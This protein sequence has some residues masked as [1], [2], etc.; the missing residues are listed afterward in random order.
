MS[1]RSVL[2]WLDRHKRL[3]A[4]LAFLALLLA[5]LDLSGL[6]GQFSLE[7]LRTRLL[8]NKLQGLAIFVLLFA[9]GN[10]IQIPGFVFLAAA[11]LALGRV[12]GGCVTY[13]AALVSCVATFLSIRLVG[14]NALR[15]FDNR[16]ATAI[17]RRLDR[18]PVVS[19]AVLR[20]LFQTAPALNYALAMSGV[21]F[22]RYLIGTV[23]GLPLP[24]ALYCLLF[25]FLGKAV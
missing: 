3:L 8:E 6:R 9:L 10:L 12:A 4:V 7:L 14:G 11:V 15:D 1:A 17:F 5:L 25:D 2:A 22:G 23:I 24:I 18:Y 21:G 20:V 13:L 19:V 16:L